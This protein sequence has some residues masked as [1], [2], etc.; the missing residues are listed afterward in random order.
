MVFGHPEK[1]GNPFLGSVGIISHYTVKN[2]QQ[3][4]HPIQE[5]FERMCIQ[6]LSQQILSD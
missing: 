1:E 4:R 2:L 5:P 3:Y 6:V